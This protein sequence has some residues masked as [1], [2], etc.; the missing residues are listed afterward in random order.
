MRESAAKSPRV[1]GF[2]CLLCYVIIKEKKKGDIPMKIAIPYEN[3]MVFQHF[4]HTAEF[5]FY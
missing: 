4:G 5:K 2:Y 1:P 3:G